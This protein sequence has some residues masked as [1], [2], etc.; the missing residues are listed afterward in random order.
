MTAYAI[1]LI[2]WGIPIQFVGFGLEN[3]KG[4]STVNAGTHDGCQSAKSLVG[5]VSTIKAEFSGSSP[6]FVTDRGYL[7]RV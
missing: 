1:T 4:W 6:A 3:L 7:Y 2:G 5:H